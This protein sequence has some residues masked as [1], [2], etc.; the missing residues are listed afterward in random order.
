MVLWM[1]Y[2]S[3]DVIIGWYWLYLLIIY[4]VMIRIGLDVTV[5]FPSHVVDPAQ[6]KN[7]PVNY[8]SCVLDSVRLV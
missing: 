6:L 4:P 2:V 3:L 8:L 5:N 7:S 1:Y